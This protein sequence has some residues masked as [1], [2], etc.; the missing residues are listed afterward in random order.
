MHPDPRTEQFLDQAT[1]GL[2]A[3][4][5]LRLDVRQELAS[6]LD[7]A[8]AEARAAGTPE[9]DAAAQALQHMGAVTDLAG[10]LATAN[11]RRMAWRARVRLA[12]TALLLPAAVL[13]AAWTV[14]QIRTETRWL[15][16]LQPGGANMISLLGADKPP[17]YLAHLSPEKRLILHGDFSRSRPADRQRAIWEAHPENRIYF[18]NYLSHVIS[19][20]CSTAL[21]NDTNEL[22]KRALDDLAQ[23]ARLDPDNARVDCLLAGMQLATAATIDAP[24][25]KGPA[26]KGQPPV[27]TIHDR[28]KLDAAMTTLLRG[29][30]KSEYR[31]YGREMTAER[32][33]L[34]GPPASFDENM[35]RVAIAASTLLPDLSSV[36]NLSRAADLYAGILAGEG[37]TDEAAR[38][39]DITP[40]LVQ[41]FAADSFTLIDLLVMQSLLES[42][43]KLAPPVWEKLGRPDR[44][45]TLRDQLPRL[46]TPMR[47][48]RARTKSL[49]APDHYEKMT[50]F[51]QHAS[52][53][54]GML[55]PVL[56]EVPPL[57][58]L[59]ASREIEYVLVEHG[60]VV[61]L[62]L[63]FTGALLAA[64]LVALRWR[65]HRGGAAAPLLLIPDAAAAGRIIGAGVL[66]PLLGYWLFT[67]WLPLA[68]R[69]L[70]IIANLVRLCLQLT[71]TAGLVAGLTT[72]LT[73]AVVRA[74]CRA[75]GVAVPK[76]KWARIGG[77]I[78]FGLLALL[79]LLMLL[80]L[81]WI[82]S[83]PNLVLTAL[84]LFTGVCIFVWLV[85]FLRFLFGSKAFGLYYGSMAR[86]LMPA[87]AVA[88]ILPGLLAGPW[89]RREEGRLVR[90][91]SLLAVAPEGG[92][93]SLENDVV[94]RLKTA[95]L[96][97]TR[98]E[99]WEISK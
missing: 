82:S 30:Q 51:N 15:A 40:R 64:G 89:L 5:E 96:D 3:D 33:A 95:T 13:T 48:Y 14:W 6:H 83:S 19:G 85:R 32:L 74:R 56:G 24:A 65:L 57:E 2:K 70:N 60:V 8:Q 26:A 52:I 21:D 46:L 67:R 1:A 72:Y 23:A 76:P 80:P 41:Y 4:R 58:S 39:L 88:V 77:R 45:A 31:R 75:L 84:G 78:Y 61:L 87:L 71:V 42:H 44:A 9:A 37:K 59:T 93:T 99:G 66:L 50:A 91:D 81:P 54:A 12:V 68:G 90:T 55:I 17:R 62:L 38:L 94:R 36:R 73:A 35:E 43:L 7:A 97:A 10:D 20:A 27:L 25:G 28:D 11:R 86:S 18:H 69:D 34:L 29:L 47:D 92:F 49:T 22:K 53:I 98:K 79:G 16:F 63:L